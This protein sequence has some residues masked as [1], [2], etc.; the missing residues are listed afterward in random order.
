MPATVTC[1]LSVSI[2][3]SAAAFNFLLA[4]ISYFLSASKALSAVAFKTLSAAMSGIRFFLFILD[5][6]TR[7]IGNSK[8]LLDH[9][10][11]P[12]I[13]KPSYLHRAS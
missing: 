11:S 6:F 4:V 8:D 13:S 1:F 7:F 2:A 9:L 12:R 3:L 10:V 5:H